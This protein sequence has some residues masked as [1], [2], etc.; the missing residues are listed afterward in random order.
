MRVNIITNNLLI[1]PAPIYVSSLPY[2]VQ[3]IHSE[4]RPAGHG[5]VFVELARTKP[6]GRLETTL[7]RRS[8]L[9][10]R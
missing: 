9:P 10:A 3:K 1:P 5:Q 2:D 8:T 6:K 7:E 4:F